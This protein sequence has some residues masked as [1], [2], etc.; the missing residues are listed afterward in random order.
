MKTFS[1]G[2]DRILKLQKNDEIH[3]LDNSTKKETVFTPTRWPLS[4]SVW[5]RSTINCV[6]SHRARTLPTKI[7]TVVDGT[8]RLRKVFDASIYANSTYYSEKQ[9][10]NPPRPVSRYV[11]TNGRVSS[12]PS[13]TYT[14]TT[15]P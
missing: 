14:A 15:Q 5:T 10:S 6:N 13:P 4:Y 8:Y 11:S 3:I 2:N 9:R 12:M 7:I 1:I